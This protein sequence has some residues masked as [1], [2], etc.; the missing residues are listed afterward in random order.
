VIAL[1]EPAPQNDCTTV[2]DMLIEIR[3][4][5]KLDII[6]LI[7][8]SQNS[9]YPYVKISCKKVRRAN[10][11]EYNYMLNIEDMERSFFSLVGEEKKAI[12]Y[13][14]NKTEIY[15]KYCPLNKYAKT[16]IY[17]PLLDF[18]NQEVVGCIYLGSIKKIKVDPEKIIGDY[19]FAILNRFILVSHRKIKKSN[20]ILTLLKL[21]DDFLI[22]N[23]SRM[24]THHYNVAY[25][26][27]K[28]ADEINMA[29]QDKVSL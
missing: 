12:F 3:D 18:E 10:Q 6:K 2:R 21:F 22:K 11:I 5:Y 23:N 9:K 29:S 4:L 28:I 14:F 17:Y 8:F 26:A 1:Y 7:Y 13:N 25:L 15:Q 19:R 20:H 24:L 27:N 16:E